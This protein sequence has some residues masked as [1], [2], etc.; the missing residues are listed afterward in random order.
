[1]IIPCN[2]SSTGTLLLIAANMVD[3]CDGAPPLRQAF[4]LTMNSSVSLRRPSLTSL[5]T[6]SAVISLA[7]LAGKISLSASRSYST[8]PFPASIRIACGAE[9][10]GS[11]FLGASLFCTGG[12]APL[13][14]GPGACVGAA[15]ATAPS[16]AAKSAATTQRP[17]AKLRCRIIEARSSLAFQGLQ[18]NPADLWPENSA[19]QNA[20][21]PLKP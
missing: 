3:P 19:Q 12:A 14:A 4:S 21:P 10:F 7:R 13:W 8:P 6:Y 16:P 17:N 5:N 20:Q 15:I 18:C 11:S 9:I 1:M 2:R